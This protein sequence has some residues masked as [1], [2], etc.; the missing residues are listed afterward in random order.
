ML[1][2]SNIYEYFFYLLKYL[3][4]VE[5]II[6]PAAQR[7]DRKRKFFDPLSAQ[8][9]T[10]FTSSEEASEEA[11]RTFGG[12]DFEKEE[13]IKD[14]FIFKP[15]EQ[16]NVFGQRAN[17]E[18]KQR[19]PT[20]PTPRTVVIKNV[21]STPNSLFEEVP[22]DF[23][24]SVFGNRLNIPD[25]LITSP[26]P[27]I[28]RTPE[29]THQNQ[30]LVNNNNLIRTKL[31]EL[32]S[33]VT[34]T[35]ESLAAAD[36][37]AN[38]VARLR[39]RQRIEATVGTTPSPTTVVPTITPFTFQRIRNDGLVNDNDIQ[40][41]FPAQID[42]IPEVARN[43]NGRQPTNP[44]VVIQKIR[45]GTNNN[46]IQNGVKNI[47]LLS[48][49]KLIESF[50]SLGKH[51]EKL[52]EQL[53]A[54]NDDIVIQNIVP[55]VKIRQRKPLFQ[56]IEQ[57]RRQQEVETTTNEIPAIKTRQRKP[58]FKQAIATTEQTNVNGADVDYS[59]DDPIT[60]S[61]LDVQLNRVR[62]LANRFKALRNNKN[63][64]V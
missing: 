58:V 36:F 53:A 11:L 17:S 57:A 54:N 45:Q 1:N 44:P 10:N 5:E 6:I 18:L 8:F 31:K 52:K 34:D 50:D 23:E 13:E 22:N 64:Q 59:D 42:N 60:Q 46:Q 28:L 12:S 33:R 14:I 48:H 41:Q 26:A 35:K 49:D 47:E 51:G 4:Q 40:S 30:L 21:F 29:P 38:N 20:S 15:L 55:E 63:V 61:T 7:P 9:Q 3:K 19:Q 32:K 16:P 25:R 62:D 56:E 37:R 2:T 39:G 27:Q 24:H 43:Q